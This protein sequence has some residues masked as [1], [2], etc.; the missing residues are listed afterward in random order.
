MAT[1]VLTRMFL[2]QKLLLTCLRVLSPI[3]VV[4]SCS[5]VLVLLLELTNMVL[6]ILTII[7][8]VLLPATIYL[9]PPRE[10]NKNRIVF[11]CVSHPGLSPVSS[12]ISVP[13]PVLPLSITLFVR[14]GLTSI[15]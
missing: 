3:S 2:K 7:L 11:L 14:S 12:V 4:F 10:T 9:Y 13:S 5:S 6:I 8:L 15:R 1:A